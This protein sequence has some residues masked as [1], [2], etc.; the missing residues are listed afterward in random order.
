MTHGGQVCESLFLPRSCLILSVCCWLTVAGLM[1]AL[2]DDYYY[3]FD[4][5][6]YEN[7]YWQYDWESVWGEYGC[8]DLFESDMGSFTFDESEKPGED[9]WPF[10]NIYGSCKTC[11]AY[12]LDYFAEEAFEKLDGFRTQGIFYGLVSL[13]GMA[14]SWVSYLRHRASPAAE[15]EIELLSNDG[16]VI[17]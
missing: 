2:S 11:D 15:N 4:D 3:E 1:F 9:D 8:T 5:D 13:V 7:E 12:L 10:V 6:Y 16:G 14:V 17:A